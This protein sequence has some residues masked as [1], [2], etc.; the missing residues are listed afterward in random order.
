MNSHNLQALQ[1]DGRFG[2]LD[3]IEKIRPLAI[4][5]EASIYA[6][7]LKPAEKWRKP[8]ALSGILFLVLTSGQALLR[9]SDYETQ[10][11]KIQ[12]MRE[13]SVRFID[14]KD[15]FNIESLYG[16][17]KL[18]ILQMPSAASYSDSIQ[19]DLRYFSNSKENKHVSKKMDEQRPFYN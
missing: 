13:D 19:V 18:L 14:S 16:N 4:H 2:N 10:K 9:I 3:D 17:T 5:Q 11:E 7:D 15:N 8:K 12:F 1:S 6:L